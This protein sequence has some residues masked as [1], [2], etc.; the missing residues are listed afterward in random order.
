MG[1][2]H[3]GAVNKGGDGQVLLQG[4]REPLGEVW[5]FERYVTDGEPGK[6]AQNATWKNVA[7]MAATVMIGARICANSY[8][9]RAIPPAAQALED[10]GLPV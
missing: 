9:N 6:V 1:P 4:G 2:E 8:P 10:Q 5:P 3:D 7:A